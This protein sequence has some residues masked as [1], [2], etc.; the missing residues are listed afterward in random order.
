[1][2]SCKSQDFCIKHWANVISSA[3]DHCYYMTSDKFLWCMLSASIRH[4]SIWWSALDNNCRK[5]GNKLISIGEWLHA[6]VNVFFIPW[7]FVE[8]AVMKHPPLCTWRP[9]LWCDGLTRWEILP[10]WR[11]WIL[12]FKVKRPTLSPVLFLFPLLFRGFVRV[13][14]L[15]ENVSLLTSNEGAVFVWL[16]RV[17]KKCEKG[18]VGYRESEWKMRKRD[19]YVKREF[20]KKKCCYLGLG[21]LFS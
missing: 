19:I 12:I 5:L 7:L 3:S 14:Y 8:K 15:R 21:F 6:A 11:V 10:V 18:W 1:M 9:V 17:L 4:Q 20:K 2:S 16:F 13:F